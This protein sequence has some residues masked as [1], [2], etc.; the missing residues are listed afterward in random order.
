MLARV[1]FSYDDKKA[2]IDAEAYARSYDIAR[3]HRIEQIVPESGLRR[4]GS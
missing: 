3:F 1:A 4:V 2:I